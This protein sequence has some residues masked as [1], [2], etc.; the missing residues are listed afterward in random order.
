[1]STSLVMQ[2]IKNANEETDEGLH[3][4]AVYLPW[5]FCL[6]KVRVC[7]W[8]GSSRSPILLGWY[9][10]FLNGPD[11]LLTLLPPYEKFHCL[12]VD[13]HDDT[14]DRMRSVRQTPK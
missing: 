10:D 1:M 12:G 4:R 14:A 5:T 11:Q 9:G 13:G 3:G 8:P 7:H 2:M 6:S